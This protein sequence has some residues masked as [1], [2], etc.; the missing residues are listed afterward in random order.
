MIPRIPGVARWS[1]ILAAATLIAVP[2]LAPAQEKKPEKPPEKQPE[3]QPDPKRGNIPRSPQESLALLKIAP[4]LEATVWASEPD[5]YKPT[6]MDIDAKGRI[7]ITEAANYRSSVVRPEGDRIIILE[8]TK[9]TGV[10]DSSK[11][12]VQDKSLVSPLGIC[13]LGNKVIVAQSPNVL[14]YTMDESG[15]KPVGPPQTLFTGFS[16]NNHDH[17]V[18][19]GVFGPD[20]QFYFNSGN[21]GTSGG[22]VK[23]GDAISQHD[24]KPVVDIT[25]T[26]VG[27]ASKQVHGHPR[28]KGEGYR[29]GLAF[30]MNLDGSDFEVLGYNF[31]NNYEL[32]VDSFGTVFQSDNDDDGNQGVRINYVMEGGNFGYT[33]PN[34]SSWGRDRDQYKKAFPDQTKPEVHWHLRWPGVVPNLLNTGQGAPCGICVYEGDLLPEIYHGA[35]LHCDAGPNVVRAY[36]TRLGAEHPTE[37][38]KPVTPDEALA[39]KKEAKPNSGAGYEAVA[40]EVLKGGDHWFR[41]DDVCVAPD[42]AV[43]VTDWY[44]PGVGGH[45][46]RDTGTKSNG[47]DWHLL[48]GRVYR[49]APEGYK[50]PAEAPKLDLES[51][52]GQVAALNS[53][54]LATRYLGYTK[55]AATLD[56]PE[57]VA[58]LKEQFETSKHNRLRARALWLL[59]RSKEGPQFVEKAL[60]DKNVNIRVAA[61]RAARRIKLDVTQFASEVLA[62][63]APAMWRE[64]CLA[65]QFDQS[66]KVLPLLVKLADKYDGSD[67]WYLEAFGIAANG[68]EKAVLEAWEKTH[69]NKDAKNNEGITWRLKLEPVQLGGLP[70]TQPSK[71]P[72]ASANGAALPFAHDNGVAAHDAPGGIE[73]LPA[74]V[75][76]TTAYEGVSGQVVFSSL[77]FTDTRLG[78]I[79]HSLSPVF[80]GEGRGEGP[81]A[82]NPDFP[83][84]PSTQLPLVG[85]A[86][87]TNSR[88]S[89]SSAHTVNQIANRISDASVRDAD[90]TS[91]NSLSP[92]LRGEGRGEGP[93][94]RNRGFPTNPS[95]QLPLVGS[96]PPT[97]SR[98]SQSSSPTANHFAISISPAM[99]RGVDPTS[100]QCGDPDPATT[101]PA[102]APSK[103][104]EK[105]FKTKDGK[106]LLPI[107]Q[108]VQLPGDPK[109]GAAVF[110]NAQ[111]ANCIK[112]HQIGD[113][114]NMIGPPLTVIGSKLNKPQFYEAILYP[115]AAIEMGYETWVVKTKD[116]EVVSGLKAEDTPDRVTIK[117]TDGKYHDID[118][119]KIDRMVK[120]T[121]SLMPEGLSE[122]MTQKDLL[123]LVEYLSTLKQ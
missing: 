100:P 48:H 110:R 105:E 50:P 86:P 82:R 112:C 39:F 21:A 79:I 38:M 90:P 53:P 84:N 61:F 106:T 58:A 63:P 20:G 78:D 122:A 62:D 2:L 15:D 18:H 9:H 46:T 42:G 73:S 94:A 52:A 17:G 32:A 49:V 66:E 72:H 102:T 55:L 34:G 41:P 33:G 59:A 57:V 108:L 101:K 8:D 116:G 16:G 29:E 113:E 23:F 26:E 99:V 117:D 12:F 114:G 31:R 3:K 7:W 92:V 87:R 109:A 30:S 89:Q 65:L 77:T 103:L 47:N 120:Q 11:V 4:G 115:S 45:A 119:D 56:K 80:R 44:D 111:G 54:N 98:I 97:I 24:G 71:E 40:V 36:V 76:S 35:I 107:D 1:A 67:R 14:I 5:V 43:Y 25:G 28:Q 70:A 6:N 96:A 13:V 118:R 22:Y 10:C 60:K 69:E 121:I 88:I 19:A 91:L 104:P 74:V 83:K 93:S 68:R 27:S 75:E 51:V 123:D 85:S 81:S 37:I 95:T 64:M